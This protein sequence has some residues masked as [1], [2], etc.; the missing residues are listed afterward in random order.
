MLDISFDDSVRDRLDEADRERLRA[1]CEAMVIAAWRDEETERELEVSLRLC[2]DE[3]IHTLNR[4]YRSMDKPT[5]VLAF[6]QREGAAG[7][8]HPELLGDIVISLDTAARQAT[9]ALF[10]EVLFLVAHGLCHLLGFDHQND[11]Q[12]AEMNERMRELLE[13]SA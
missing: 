3:V 9:G 8:P 2:D 7:N 6:A 4:E 5:D 12:E 11:E 10:D 13:A 1:R